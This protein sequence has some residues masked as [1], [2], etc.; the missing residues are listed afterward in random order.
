M[1]M[2]TTAGSI[3]KSRGSLK[4]TVS[5]LPA[6]VGAW[7]SAGPPPAAEAQWAMPEGSTF[8]LYCW[9]DAVFLGLLPA[10]TSTNTFTDTPAPK[11]RGKSLPFTTTRRNPKGG[12]KV[13]SIHGQQTSIMQK[14]HEQQ[15]QA[16]FTNFG[17]C[18]CPI[19]ASYNIGPHQP[20]EATMTRIIKPIINQACTKERL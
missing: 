2:L 14:P 13:G 6:A 19:V 16:A 3:T 18:N 7:A 12:L 9:I 4:K 17:Q 15:Q 5:S 1:V 8:R 11:P 10:L 20:F